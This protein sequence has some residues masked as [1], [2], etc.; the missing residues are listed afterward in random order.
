MD[1]S[2]KSIFNLEAKERKFFVKI[3]INREIYSNDNETSDAFSEK[4]KEFSQEINSG[5]R[6]VDISFPGL[7]NTCLI[8]NG[9]KCIFSSCLV[10]IIFIILALGEI[11]ELI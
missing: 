4:E 1:N 10:Y 3:I 9:N 6:W 5:K 7:K 11:Y 2:E 8:T